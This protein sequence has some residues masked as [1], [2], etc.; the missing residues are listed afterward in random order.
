MGI[1]SLQEMYVTELA[2]K[3]T[4]ALN[5]KGA[6]GQITHHLLQAQLNKVGGMPSQELADSLRHSR[7]LR[8]VLL[9]DACGG[10]M[11]RYVGGERA[12]WYKL[13][14]TQLTV[15]LEKLRHDPKDLGVS[16]R[17]PPDISCLS[18]RWA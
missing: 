2:A 5:D 15:L 10:T 4:G 12:E 14:G 1:T 7:L 8:T 18:L 9:L 17:V 3:L 13:T 11:M 16:T 6:L